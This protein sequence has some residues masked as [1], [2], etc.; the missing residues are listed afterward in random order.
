MKSSQPL[1]ILQYGVFVLCILSLVWLS[2][3]YSYAQ[4]MQK[5]KE[6]SMMEE[7]FGDEE[8]ME[9]TEIEMGDENLDAMEMEEEDYGF[10]EDEFE[11]FSNETEEDSMQDDPESSD[12]AGMEEGSQEDAEPT[13]TPPQN[14]TYEEYFM[15]VRARAGGDIP[16]DI[17]ADYNGDDEI[18]WKDRE[19]YVEVLS[20]NPPPLS[21]P[22]SSK[23]SGGSSPDDEDEAS[24]ESEFD[25]DTTEEG[26]DSEAEG[27]SEEGADEE[28]MMMEE[29]KKEKD[30]ETETNTMQEEPQSMDITKSTSSIQAQGEEASPMD[31]FLRRN[32]GIAFYDAHLEALREENYIV[33]TLIDAYNG[34]FKASENSDNYPY[35]NNKIYLQKNNERI[36]N[37][38]IDAFA[39]EADNRLLSTILF[40]EKPSNPKMN[41]GYILDHEK[42][43]YVEDGM[44]AMFGMVQSDASYV[45]ITKIQQDSQEN[46]EIK[47]TQ[48]GKSE[49][50]IDEYK[51]PNGEMM[52]KTT[53]IV[54][55]ETNLIQ[56]MIF[57]GA[58]E[59]SDLLV[60]FEYETISDSEVAEHK[61]IPPDYTEATS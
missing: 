1:R 56:K 7:S 42:K 20:T 35:L 33:S 48:A 38:R 14:P 12:E 24:D 5:A 39:S 45:Y 18:D 40:L 10:A 50:V 21:A 30:T 32:V 6:D 29:E 58:I 49:W 41:R 31:S 11:E 46:R 57:N 51:R 16:D 19:I 9:G 13:P 34:S 4:S 22:P 17:T 28:N 54:N 25:S 44:T 61:Q 60:L 37:Y 23:N 36:P 43:T 47:I 15:L 26:F 2:S 55:P 53:I 59:G 52:Y 8:E 3:P 27:N